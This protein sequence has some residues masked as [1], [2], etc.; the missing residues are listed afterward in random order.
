MLKMTALF[1]GDCTN[2]NRSLEHS[3]VLSVHSY[4]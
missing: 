2:G 4:Q 1:A 3:D